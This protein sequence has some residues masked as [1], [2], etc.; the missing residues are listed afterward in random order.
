MGEIGKIA[1]TSKATVQTVTKN[2][3]ETGSYHSKARNG[4]LSK[5]SERQQRDI[6][7]KVSVKPTVSTR[8][9]ADNVAERDNLTVHPEIASLSQ[10]SQTSFTNTSKKKTFISEANLRKRFT[11]AKRY[12][13]IHTT[14][15]VFWSS[16]SM[17]SGKMGGAN[18]G[19]RSTKR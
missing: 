12:R 17:Y 11:F 3:K 9:I 10:K 19:G 2:W 16:H 14:K 1:G 18:Y 8:T 7:R 15:P 5:L 6:V 4:H 13:N